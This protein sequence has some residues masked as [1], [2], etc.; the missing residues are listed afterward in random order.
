MGTGSIRW[1]FD[2]IKSLTSKP[3]DASARSFLAYS[4]LQSLAGS[5]VHLR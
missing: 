4:E 5:L 1:K 3:L 2:A